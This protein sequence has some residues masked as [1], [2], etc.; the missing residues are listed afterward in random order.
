MTTIDSWLT[1]QK[2]GDGYATVME[3][4]EM[5]DCD[6][7]ATEF[8]E[9]Y[10]GI[11]QTVINVS[12]LPTALILLLLFILPAQAA[13]DSP[14]VSAARLYPGVRFHDGVRDP[15]LVQLAQEA[16]D[17]MARRGERGYRWDGHPGWNQRHAEIR[18]KLGMA[19]VEV[20]AMERPGEGDDIAREAFH[21]WRQSAGHWR[22]V[23]TPH[24]RFGDG[25]ARS[26]RGVYFAVIIVAD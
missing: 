16:A 9:P 4:L 2:F 8:D 11:R 12:M 15:L 5:R 21:D 1:I 25:L 18:R 26:R 20:S 17:A 14:L 24:K 13:D 6:E 23:A 3:E 7:D 22:V 10:R 19:G